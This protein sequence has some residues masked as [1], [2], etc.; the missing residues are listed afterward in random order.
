MHI[1]DVS[2]LYAKCFYGMTK[3]IPQSMNTNSFS[4]RFHLTEKAEYFGRLR[5]SRNDNL[6]WS[7]DGLRYTSW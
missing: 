3:Q 4:H 1:Y 6:A 7:L 2:L 5:K